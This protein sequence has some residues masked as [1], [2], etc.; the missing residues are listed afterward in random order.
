MS[1]KVIVT[2]GLGIAATVL[3]IALVIIPYVAHTDIEYKGQMTF[4]TQEDF[5]KFKYDLKMRVY[6]DDL[7]L[8]SFDVL[9]SEPPIIVNFQVVVPYNY[10]MPY[11]TTDDLFISKLSAII[12]SIGAVFLLIILPVGIV[13][14]KKEG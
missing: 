11:G 5:E 7:K 3:L 10:D 2:L 13:V 12:A 1:S 9:S 14:E 8:G 4:L 6:N